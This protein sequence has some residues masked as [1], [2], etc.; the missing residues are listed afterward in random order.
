VNI[1]ANVESMLG[2]LEVEP[3]FESL[4]VGQGITLLPITAQHAAGIRTIPRIC[5]ATTPLIGC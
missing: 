1:G 3:E 4:L 2:K 5:C